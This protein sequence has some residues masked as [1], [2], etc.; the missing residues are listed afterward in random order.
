M[1]VI[2][3]LR[4]YSHKLCVSISKTDNTQRRRS[5][6]HHHIKYCNILSASARE[7]MKPAFIICKT[8]DSS[9]CKSASRNQCFK[10]Y[11]CGILALMCGSINADFKKRLPN[12]L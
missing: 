3:Y 8:S 1:W 7:S 4:I 12:C 2:S 10:A 5:V 9:G 11:I 6:R